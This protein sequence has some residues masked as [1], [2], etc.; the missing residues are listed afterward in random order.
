MKHKFLTFA[1]AAMMLTPQLA[2]D[3]VAQ[4]SNP[5]L[6]PYTAKYEIPPF[7][8]IKTEHFIPAL[9]VGIEEQNKN[10]EAIVNNSEAPTFDNTIMPLENLSPILDRVVAVYYHYDNAMS[11]PEHAAIADEIVPMI[12][13]A[14]NQ[15]MLNDALF[16]RIKSVYDNRN[17]MKLDAVQKRV[18]EK[19]YRRFA[20]QGA[21]LSAEKKEE[22]VKVN[23][24]L[25]TN[26]SLLLSHWNNIESTI[27]KI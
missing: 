5:F 2:T 10:L 17:K 24:W 15:V 12:N 11:S 4:E 6:K 16:Q 3:V 27:F 7:E 18:V 25:K 8:E 21:A 9:K 22:L 19:Y 13:D 23:N 20:E 1:A 26:L 14:S